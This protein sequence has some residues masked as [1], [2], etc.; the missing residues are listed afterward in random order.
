[1]CFFF[2]VKY[3]FSK[4]SVDERVTVADAVDHFAK[5]ITSLELWAGTH[6]R[7]RHLFVPVK[8]W[9][10]SQQAVS[11]CSDVDSAAVIENTDVVIDLFLVHIQSM[12]SA[13][14]EPVEE[15][16]DERDRYIEQDYH[17][18]RNLTR[19]LKLKQTIDSLDNAVLQL[20]VHG[21]D[22]QT[23]LQRF[24]PFL[25]LYL[26]LAQHQLMAHS[27][28]TKALFKLD[29]VLCSVTQTIAKDGFCKPPDADEAGAG[30][31]TSEAT[32]GMGLGAGEGSENVSKEIEEESQVEGLKGDD[33]QGKDPKD[34]NDDNDA[35]EMSEDI[36]GNLEDVPEDEESQNE[37]DSDQGSDSDPEEQLGDLDASD[38]SAVDEKLWGDEQGPQDSTEKDDKTNQD[39]SEQKSG[40]SEVVAKE[41]EQPQPKE[42]KDGGEQPTDQEPPSNAEDEAMAEGEE[43]QDDHPDAS[44]APMEDYIQDANTLD[45]PDDM[46]LGLGEE[47]ADEM[48]MDEGPEEDAMVEDDAEPAPETEP[49]KEQANRDEPPTEDTPDPMEGQESE[50]PVQTS[51]MAEDK[52]ASEDEEAPDDHAVAQPDVTAGEG[53]VDPNSEKDKAAGESAATGQAGSSAG[54][55]G[56]DTAASE[57]KSKDE[58]GYVCYLLLS[59]PSLIHCLVP[60]NPA[61]RLQ[62]HR[63]WHP[64]LRLPGHPLMA[65]RRDTPSHNPMRN[66]PATLYVA[67]VMR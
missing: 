12:L 13:C 61:S 27:E 21:C 60:R 49:S 22:I 50:P 47:M 30:G 52:E 58:D 51:E 42:K 67:S 3:P 11:L 17:S 19:L 36:G 33:D 38:P 66:L 2:L 64:S 44:G 63:L 65:R 37:K 34:R 20:A 41:G 15:D 4:T 10:E 40:D 31:D 25:N 54:V 43:D 45:L 62:R 26:Q 16:S 18:V 46:D 24:L 6:P 55:A 5:T 23:H 28:W 14:P 57:E 53:E 35:I 9:L 39:H 1:L 48:E 29:F 32:G 7:L 8:F 59:S 56:Q